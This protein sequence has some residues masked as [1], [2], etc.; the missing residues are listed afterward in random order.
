LLRDVLQNRE[1]A[2]LANGGEGPLLIAGYQY[3]NQ[4]ASQ[5]NQNPV[6]SNL[7]RL[8]EYLSQLSKLL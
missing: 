2:Y 3:G 7:Q 1:F 6:G 4:G 8:D 5:G